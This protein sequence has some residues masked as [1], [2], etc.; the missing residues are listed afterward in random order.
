MELD[1]FNKLKAHEKYLL[2][3]ELQ[4]FFSGIK[5]ILII[6]LISLCGILIYTILW[7]S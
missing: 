5:F 7:R 6:F 1:E 4:A 2:K 3:W